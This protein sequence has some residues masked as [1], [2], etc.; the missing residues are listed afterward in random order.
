MEIRVLGHRTTLSDDELT[1]RY[2]FPPGITLRANFVAT[3]D[4]SATGTDG[5]SGSINNAADKHVYDLNRRLCDVV[6]VGASTAMIENYRPGP[7]DSPPLVVVSNSG[8]I[9]DGWRHLG[10][11]TG[12][13]LICPESTLPER[14]DSARAVLGEDQVWLVGSESVDLAAVKTTLGERG[15]PKILCEGGPRLHA[16]LHAAG[17]VDQLA[18]SVV[19]RLAGG[20]GPRIA[21]G[22]Q[23]DTRLRRRHLLEIDETLFGLWDIG[24]SCV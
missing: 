9:P 20:S 17:L 11:S 4:G 13:I 8:R 5:R 18:L 14:L 2:A 10:D 12:A 7:P 23:L 6:L 1:D 19:P 15:W 24:L 22:L 16:A 21:H 3:I